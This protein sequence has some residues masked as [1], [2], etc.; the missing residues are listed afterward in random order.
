MRTILKIAWN[1]SIVVLLVAGL[2]VAWYSWPRDGPQAGPSAEWTC[3]MHPQ[4]RQSGPGKCPICGMDL[5]PRG[6][7]RLR[8]GRT[9]D[10]AGRLP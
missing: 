5:I 1:V 4:I 7:T 2:G 10:G 8:A 3:S 9:G 6:T